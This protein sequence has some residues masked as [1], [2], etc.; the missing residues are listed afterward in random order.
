MPNKSFGQREG[1]VKM[2]SNKE[3]IQKVAHEFGAT[4]GCYD[5]LLDSLTKKELDKVL[6]SIEFQNDTDV[7]IKRKKYVVEIDVVENEV[8]FSV[9]TK[10]EFI[11]R[12]GNERWDND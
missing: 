10:E 11:N 2:M 9:L 7:S 6:G 4:I 5:K 8:D 1:K 3:K 12:Y